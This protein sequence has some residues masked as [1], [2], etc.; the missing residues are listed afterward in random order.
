M[1][2][3]I[4]LFPPSE[5]PDPESLVVSNPQL[6]IICRA[7]AYLVLGTDRDDTFFGWVVYSQTCSVQ[8][9]SRFDYF[10][11]LKEKHLG[12]GR[13]KSLDKWIQGESVDR[14]GGLLLKRLI[15]NWK[16]RLQYLVQYG[17]GRLLFAKRTD[18]RK[19]GKHGEIIGPPG[20]VGEWWSLRQDE[21]ERV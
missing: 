9:G 10:R 19:R 1:N 20:F 7:R 3:P 11:H 15:Q 13:Q 21:K 14:V 12:V 6:P 8:F 2:E 4:F 18:S 16:M 5:R 17:T